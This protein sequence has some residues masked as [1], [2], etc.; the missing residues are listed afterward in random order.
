MHKF[1]TN[2]NYIQFFFHIFHRKTKDEKIIFLDNFFNTF[3]KQKII[4]F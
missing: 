3:L 4:I 2:F 1:L